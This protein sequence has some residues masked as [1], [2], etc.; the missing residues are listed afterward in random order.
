MG[1]ARL[2][3]PRTLRGPGRLPWP[4]VN[5]RV[6][7]TTRTHRHISLMFERECHG[8]VTGLTQQ[9][10]WLV[11]CPLH[12]QK[13]ILSLCLMRRQDE[14]AARPRYSSFLSVTIDRNPGAR[15]GTR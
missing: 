2:P 8:C 15:H 6:G 7:S 10:E 12:V 3:A 14:V 1:F 11:S 9:V 13:H 5:A 4:A